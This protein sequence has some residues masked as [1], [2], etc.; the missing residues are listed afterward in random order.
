[1]PVAMNELK[2]MLD[3]IQQSQTFPA[4]QHILSSTTQKLG[5]TYFALT[6]H[7]HPS[8]WPTLAIGLHNCP[9]DWIE[10]YAVNKLYKIDPI[11]HAS[12][13][14]TLGF[15]WDE[16]SSIIEMTPDR[17]KLLHIYAKAGVSAGMTIPVH[18]PGEPTGSCSFATKTGQ[19]F[20]NDNVVAAQMIGAF[21]FQSAR[22]I[23]GLTRSFRL[24][25]PSLTPRQ[26]D[27]LLWAM[28][29]KS[30]WEIAQILELSPDTVKQH[31][32]RARSRYGVAKRVQLAI[33]AIY[34]GDIHFDEV[35][36]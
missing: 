27:C 22:K 33:R 24:S 35:V 16:L 20:P 17:Q 9:Q 36:F 25:T 3:S 32:D 26:R 14:T 29:G 15:R 13:L 11:L 1:M 31:L 12:T 19:T 18:I 10:S 30:D 8:Q 21:S 4:L 7:A 2:A 6:H 28:R 23:A 5:F 34:L